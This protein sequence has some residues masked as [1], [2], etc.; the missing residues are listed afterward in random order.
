MLRLIGKDFTLDISRA[1]QELGYTPVL[2]PEAGF[3]AMEGSSARPSAGHPS[4]RHGTS[5]VAAEA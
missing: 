1:R 5:T 2:T 3:R 4:T